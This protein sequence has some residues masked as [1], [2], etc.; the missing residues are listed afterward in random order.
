MGKSLSNRNW[1]KITNEEKD[2]YLNDE[3]TW[4]IEEFAEGTLYMNNVE[5][6]VVL[7][8]VF[9]TLFSWI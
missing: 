6:Y 2:K 5:G 1:E 4:L 7:D 9:E 3:Q 8:R